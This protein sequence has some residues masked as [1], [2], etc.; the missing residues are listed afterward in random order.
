V[1]SVGLESRIHAAFAHVV[2]GFVAGTHGPD[3]ISV[4]AGWLA[5]STR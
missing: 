1:P 4:A 2:G 3:A 5:S